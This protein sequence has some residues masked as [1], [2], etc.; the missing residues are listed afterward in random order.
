MTEKSLC[1]AF[2]CVPD[3]RLKIFCLGLHFMF[4]Y[5]SPMDFQGCQCRSVRTLHCQCP[6]ARIVL[7]KLGKYFTFFFLVQRQVHQEF[8]SVHPVLVGPD[9]DLTIPEISLPNLG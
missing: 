7:K 9:M 4:P 8:A 1:D 2:L 3:R 6:L 5:M